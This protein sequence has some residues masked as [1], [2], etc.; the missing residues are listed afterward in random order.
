[1][2]SFIDFIPTPLDEINGF[3]ELAELSESDVVYDLGSGDG[4]LLFAALEQ[5]AGKVVGV[6]LN[7]QSINAARETARQKGVQDRVTFLQSDVME[8]DLSNA[9]VV[10]C[11]L[12]LG[13]ASA[14]KP[15]FESELKT[16]SRVVMEMYPVPGWRS[17]RTTNKGKKR[18]YLY[19][20]PPEICEED[21]AHDPLLDYLNSPS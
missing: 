18:F 15:K 13:A 21:T 1:M 11:Y 8:T 16:G 9:S 6:E 17:V 5:G 19:N 20:M 2:P 7:A 3:F 4:R 10:L 12:S 14:L